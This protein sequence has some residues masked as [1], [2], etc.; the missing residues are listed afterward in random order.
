MVSLAALYER[1]EE[2]PTHEA[3]VEDFKATLQQGDDRGYVNFM[4]NEGTARV[5]AAYPGQTWERLAAIKARYDPTN[6]FHLNQN[7]PPIQK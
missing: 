2:K 1:P 6:L 3:W 4:G 5:H 7:I